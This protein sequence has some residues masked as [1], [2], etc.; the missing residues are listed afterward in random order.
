MRPEESSCERSAA[1][2][3]EFINPLNNSTVNNYME[4]KSSQVRINLEQK[5]RVIWT[6]QLHLKFLKAINALGD[7]KSKCL[8]ILFAFSQ[9][10]YIFIIFN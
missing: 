10:N 9:V 7:E 4:K 3:V 2:K 6:P 1:R 8:I 5:Q